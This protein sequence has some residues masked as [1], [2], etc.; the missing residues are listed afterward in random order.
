[1]LPKTFDPTKRLLAGTLE[2][3]G[4]DA[5]TVQSRLEEELAEL[6]RQRPCALGKEARQSLL[7]L[8]HDLPQ[9]WDHHASSPD[10]NKRLLRT[11]INEIVVSA[12]GD[13]VRMIVHW[14]GGDH[15]E[16]RLKKTPTGR[17]RYVT[18]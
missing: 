2:R 3:R 18:S 6:M 17:H 16:L 12:D 13:S 5:M 11:V 1:M 7:A 8:A 9:L 14:Q 4:N 15:T 10:I